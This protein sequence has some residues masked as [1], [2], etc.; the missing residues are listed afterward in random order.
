MGP[1]FYKNDDGTLL[2]AE[3]SVHGP[4]WTLMD[5]SESTDGWG[6]FPTEAAARQAYSI[7]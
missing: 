5:E 6:Y 4:G 1:G 3:V 2:Y 7:E